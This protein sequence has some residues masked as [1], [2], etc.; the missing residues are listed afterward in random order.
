V[1]IDRSDDGRLA[2]TW[3]KAEMVDQG[4]GKRPKPVL[5]VGETDTS[6]ADTI[7]SAVGQSPEYTFL[8]EEIGNRLNFRKTSVVT[9][10]FGQTSVPGIFAGGDI[11]NTTADAISAIADGHR[12][13]QGID[14]YLS[15]KAQELS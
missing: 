11:V 15:N 10:Q 1:Q 8:S 2:L 13:A 7:V 9:D 12:A 6:I 3:A 14:F 4:P 5:I